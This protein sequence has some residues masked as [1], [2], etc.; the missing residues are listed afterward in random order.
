VT[1][2]VSQVIARIAL[3]AALMA[4]VVAAP[5]AGAAEF[6]L[7]PADKAVGQIQEYVVRQGEVL[8]DIARQFDVGYTE[9]L[10]AN[11]GINPWV[12]PAGRK[13]LIPTLYV[14]PD[15]PRTGIV[16]NLGERRLYYFPPGGGRVETFP[17]GIGATGFDTPH[18]VTRV[19]AKIADP[20]WVPP[21]SIRAEQPDLPA[22]I[23]PGPDNPLGAYELRLGWKNYLIHGT[24]KPDGVGRNVSHGCI[25]LYPED[26]EKLFGEAA[27]GTPVRV[28]E[29][30]ASAAWVGDALY[31]EAHP[32]KDQADEVD[33]QQPMTPRPPQG[34]REMVN[35]AAGDNAQT[36]DWGAVDRAGMQR[37]G[38]P[39]I[40]A[41]RSG[42]PIASTASPDVAATGAPAPLWPGMRAPPPPE[43][44]RA[45]A[46]I[47]NTLQP[48]PPPVAGAVPGTPVPLYP[49]VWGSQNAAVQDAA[50]I[51]IDVDDD[52]PARQPRRLKRAPSPDDDPDRSAWDRRTR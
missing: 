37:R 18:S 38:L 26:I 2:S 42:A 39:V 25:H 45:P 41:R 6:P 23:G 43:L 49:G 31:L 13:L 20:P 3:G 30:E 12:P 40:V 24:N 7:S 27:V 36:L 19:V 4:A 51:P 1:I 8:A 11:P 9:I 33:V 14:L 22:A 21:P 5:R 46:P 47:F 34:L 32:D 28:I 10:A 52:G 29:Q 44:A 16:L 17:I 35:A 48:P 50:G 15:A